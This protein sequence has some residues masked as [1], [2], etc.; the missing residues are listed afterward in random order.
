VI[1]WFGSRP[2][3][4]PK[5]YHRPLILRG[6]LIAFY[7]SCWSSVLVVE[8]LQMIVHERDASLTFL[9][10]VPST[11]SEAS[12]VSVPAVFPFLL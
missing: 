4:G 9:M 8:M 2:V 11:S 5:K 7:L 10:L 1:L 12:S 3:F 6:F